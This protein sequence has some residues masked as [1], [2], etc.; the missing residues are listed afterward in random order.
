MPSKD[1]S[2]TKEITA[3]VSLNIITNTDAGEGTK[4][5]DYYV[6]YYNATS[7][8]IKFVKSTDVSTALDANVYDGV[9]LKLIKT[10]SDEQGKLR[11]FFNNSSVV[12]TTPLFVDDFDEG[13]PTTSFTEQPATA[14]NGRIIYKLDGIENLVLVDTVNIADMTIE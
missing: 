6:M 7:K 9:A 10:A 13:T 8:A 1:G 5:N 3:D 14:V 12:I 4:D 11:L 2:R